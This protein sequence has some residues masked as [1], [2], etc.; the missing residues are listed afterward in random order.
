MKNEK[1]RGHARSRRKLSN[2][3]LILPRRPNFYLYRPIFHRFYILRIHTLLLWR[4]FCCLKLKRVGRCRKKNIE[5]VYCLRNPHEGLIKSAHNASELP[6]PIYYM[7]HR[8]VLGNLKKR[9]GSTKSGHSIPISRRRGRRRGHR[10][11]HLVGVGHQRQN[12][13]Q[14]G[15]C[16]LGIVQRLAAAGAWRRR[17][18]YC[19]VHRQRFLKMGHRVILCRRVLPTARR[20]RLA[21]AAVAGPRE[22]QRVAAGSR[23]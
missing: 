14:K 6:P 16:M 1:D 8:H 22:R 12:G 7:W 11:R 15:F 20:L 18:R 10:R 13:P 17:W 3:A 2:P 21:V 9:K 23:Q 5:A 19:G 4:G